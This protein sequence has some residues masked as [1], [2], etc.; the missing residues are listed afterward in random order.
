MTAA[1]AYLALLRAALWG[2]D[3]PAWEDF[4]PVF[5]EALELCDR[6]KT[7]GLAYDLLLRSGYPVPAESA[8]RMQQL[9]YRILNT[10]RKQNA[11][12]ARVV[13][14]LQQADIPCVLLKGQGVA[15]FYPNPLLRECGDIDLY[16][17]PE[18]LPDAVRAATPLSDNP[19]RSEMNDKHYR[20][21]IGKAEFE[22][23]KFTLI[24]VRCRIA[25][26]YRALEQAALRPENTL[27]VIF[28]DVTVPVPD[29]TFNALYLFAHIWHHFFNG[30]I[31]LRQF[32]DWVLLLHR[33][34]AAI[35]RERLSRML[36]R[37]GLLSVWQRL[38][39]I[40]V[41]ELGLP[42]ED[43][44]FYDGRGFAKSRI[45]L[46]LILEEGNFGE[47]RGYRGPDRPD[48]YLSGKIYAFR[49]HLKRFFLMFPVA[50]VETFLYVF[51]TAWMGTSNSFKDLFHR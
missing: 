51:K 26:R 16:V 40:A 2:T 11:A 27:P 34:R 3:I 41:H 7:R 4:A 30:G 6:Q 37:L 18:R 1:E 49:L 20:F 33:E 50:P 32:C 42:E 12:L 36:S 24:P 47:A 39:C 15:R 45:I 5:D 31:G 48:G 44:P 22:L 25:R 19:E 23:H 10:H 9:L 46:D 8:G 35:D 17:G 14:I 38:G 21:W 29:P 28:D 13:S 43:F